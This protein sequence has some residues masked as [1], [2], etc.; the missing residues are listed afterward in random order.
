M[1]M[2]PTATMR[3]CV[4]TCREPNPT[5][6][7]TQPLPHE[8][9]GTPLRDGPSGLC[10][11]GAGAGL[12]EDA[13]VVIVAPLFVRVGI[14]GGLR[15]R[16]GGGAGAVRRARGTGEDG[17]EDAATG[18]SGPSSS[19]APASV[20]ENGELAST[21]ISGGSAVSAASA[22][23]CAGGAPSNEPARS[24]RRALGAAVDA[25]ATRGREMELSLLPLPSRTS[26]LRSRSL[27]GVGA[28]GVWLGGGPARRSSAL[29][30]VLSCRGRPL[31]L[32]DTA[33]RVLLPLACRDVGEAA[34]TAWSAGLRIWSESRLLT[35]CVSLIEFECL[36]LT[37]RN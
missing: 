36:G 30:L 3:A 24:R 16:G 5:T 13:I 25:A 28:E 9:D 35:L 17:S 31:V 21:R 14:A 4:H 26:R 37:F 27:E 34:V 1:Q 8:C 20:G 2:R 10:S 29:W 22:R 18:E 6:H 15:L 12:A 32:P 23:T 11:R 7:A 19:C 33:R